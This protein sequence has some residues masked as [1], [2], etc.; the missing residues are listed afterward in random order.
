M[1][2]TRVALVTGGNRGIGLEIVRQ[3]ARGGMIVCLGARDPEKGATARDTLAA[4]GLETVLLPLD[5]SYAGS[6]TDAFG[7]IDA[8]FG[9]LDVLVNNA[10]ILIDRD[11]EGKS[12]ATTDVAIDI[13]KATFDVNVVGPL[14][15]IQAAVPRM[16]SR[17]YGRIVNM[18][19]MLGQLSNMGGGMPAYRA[20]KAALNALTRTTAAELGDSPV[21]VNAMSPGWVRTD[22]GGP[23]AARS[24]E[25]GADTA[26]WLATLEDD[27]PTGL[28]FQDRAPIDW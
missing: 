6:V 8:K 13:F 5:V 16:Q 12:H 18:S 25:E 14:R 22:M 11:S 1:S 27:G 26:T 23:N 4:E 3:L 2:E 24:V 17:G 10:G 19:S 21:K 7:E 20:S 15:T 9:R 28:F